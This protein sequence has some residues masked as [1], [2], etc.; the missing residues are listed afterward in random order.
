ME[1]FPRRIGIGTHV[2]PRREDGDYNKSA[3]WF[4]RAA[5]GNNSEAQFILGQFY[6][7][8]VGVERNAVEAVVWLK[9]AA[10]GGHKGAQ[11]LLGNMYRTGD[12]VM[13]NKDESDRWYEMADGK[14]HNGRK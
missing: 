12:G 14:N 5:T 6:K 13:V 10:I 4:E 11:I 9:T 7:A 1:R 3:K 2:F 8:G